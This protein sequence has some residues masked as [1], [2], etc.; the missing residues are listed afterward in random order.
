MRLQMLF[1]FVGFIILQR[2]LELAHAKR[3][4]AWALENGGREHAPEHYPY[5]VLLHSIWIVALLLEGWWRGG[6]L[7]MLWWLWLGLFVLAQVGRYHVISS[8]GKLWNTRIVIV[9]NAKL[10]RTGLYQYFKHP[11]YMVV[12]LELLVA[13]LVFGA[14]VTALVFGVLNAVLLLV[15]R[16]PAEE[17]ALATVES[18]HGQ[19]KS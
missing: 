5:M 10:V 2:L 11:N 13:P 12:A 19:P 18:V 16:I 4:L 15:Y 6:S 8:L 1:V 3:N 9:P 14:W 17:K 7:A